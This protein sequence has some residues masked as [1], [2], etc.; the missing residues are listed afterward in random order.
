M[1][2]ESPTET[3]DLQKGHSSRVEHVIYMQFDSWHLQLSSKVAGDSKDFCCGDWRA[4]V[5][6][7]RQHGVRWIQKE[8]RFIGLCP[9]L[10][11][12]GHN[13]SS[14]CLLSMNNSLPG[15]SLHHWA[16][17]LSTNYLCHWIC[18]RD[19]LDNEECWEASPKAGLP[20]FKKWKSWQKSCRAF[21]S[22]SVFRPDAVCE[23]RLPAMS[24]KFWMDGN[25]T[26]GR[27]QTGWMDEG[28]WWE[29]ASQGRALKMTP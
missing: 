21:F 27:I 7:G 11:H 13:F 14:S 29:P 8:S 1:V 5:S 15:N 24:R 3:Q 18:V 9:K 22:F 23:G 16:I 26:P 2:I 10:L 19:R 6:H 12:L 28:D 17:L 25:P 4:N 20:Y